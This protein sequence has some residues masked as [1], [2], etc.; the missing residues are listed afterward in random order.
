[1]RFRYNPIQRWAKIIYRKFNPVL[2]S[3]WTKGKVD[4]ICKINLVPPETLKSFF[5]DC[6]KTLQG[7]KGKEIG[8]YLEFGVF[9]GSS[10]GSA[11]LTAKKLNLNSMRFFGFDAFQ[12]LPEETDEEHDVLQ[13]GFYACSFEKMKEC[14]K[15]RNVNPNDVIWIKGWY[16]DTLNDKTIKK[17]NIKKI[18]IVF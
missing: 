18:G 9:N 7:I 6:I 8:D 14:L 10:L 2:G 5:S 4:D 3:A 13:K 15:R 1:M 11:Y 16:K 12:G 17:H